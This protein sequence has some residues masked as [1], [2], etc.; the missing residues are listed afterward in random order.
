LKDGNQVIT[1]ESELKQHVHY[2]VLQK[3]FWA[4]RDN[5]FSLYKLRR[6]DIPQVNSLENEVLVRNFTEEE[7]RAAF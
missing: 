1:G 5:D 6:D 2:H 7:V 3:A 4:T